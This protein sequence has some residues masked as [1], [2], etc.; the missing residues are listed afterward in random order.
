M[1]P[2]T[3]NSQISCEETFIN[4]L[5]H[6]E[7]VKIIVHYGDFLDTPALGELRIRLNCAVGVCNATGV[8]LFVEENCDDP[9]MTA[10]AYDPYLKNFEVHVISN[11]ASEDAGS[12]SFYFPGFVDTHIHASQYPNCG[13]FGDST[14]L[15]WLETYTFPLESSLS[16]ENAAALTYNAVISQT[17]KHG[18]TCAAYYTTIHTNSSKI[19][20]DLCKLKGQR[21]FVGKVCMDQHSPSYYQETIQECK[22]SSLELVKYILDELNSPLVRPIITPRFAITCSSEMMT[23]LA[24]VAEQFDVPIQTHL[25]E[26]TSEIEFVKELFKDCESYTDV[27][28]KHG[29]LNEKTV[30]AHCVHLEETEIK[31]IKEASAG[32]SHCPI[33]NSSLTSGE[34]RVK[35]L[36]KTGLKVGLG[37]DVSGGFTVSILENARQALLVSRHLAMTMDDST[38]KEEVKLSVADVLYLATMG[39][40]KVLNLCGKIGTFDVGKEFDAQLIDLFA[41]KTNVSIFPWQ[42]VDKER[43]HSNG[44]DRVKMENIVAKWLFNGDDRNIKSVWIGGKLR[45]QN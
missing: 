23:F 19:M 8:I 29:L 3:T 42:R 12:A 33:S 30:L 35:E 15:D 34:C 22:E 2:V 20:A 6:T 18:T 39:G 31:L 9:L 40:A 44:K 24:D 17:L 21:A 28:R 14:L 32:I 41:D 27:Y 36:L 5:P 26:N 37:S 38:K 11:K 45:H 13:I 4:E 1:A 25:N 10:L 16:D 43:L 7:E